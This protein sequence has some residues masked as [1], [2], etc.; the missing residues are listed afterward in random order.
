MTGER[1]SDLLPS[2]DEL[3]W[4]TP[5]QIPVRTLVF[6]GRSRQGLDHLDTMPGLPP[7][8]RGPYATMYVQR[9]WT[10]RQYAG[11]STA[12]GLQRLLPAQSRCGAKG[13][14]HRVRSGDAPRLRL[15][16]SPRVSGDVGMAG[17]AIDS[18][19]DMRTLFD[20]IPLD[21][22]ERVD[23]DERCRAT[24]HGALHRRG[25]RARESSR[26]SLPARSRT[27]S[28]KSSWFATRTSI[29]PQLRACASSPTISL[30]TP[31]SGCRSSTASASA[32]TT[33]R[34]QVRP[35]TW[36]LAYTLADGA[37]V[38]THRCRFGRSRRRRLLSAA[39]VFLGDWHE[40]LHGGC[41]AASRPDDLG[42][43]DQTRSHQRTTRAFRCGRTAKRAAGA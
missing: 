22:D 37:R 25:G 13:I 16:S 19:Q 9:P 27:T 39:V 5:E 10:V 28:L 21:Q 12:K 17:V 42:E 1:R 8:L 18:I 29:R 36:N 14:K 26:S 7:F 15:R 38:R 34:K 23:D 20:G 2:E 11:F 6:G 31:A 41:E 24:D 43:A 33:C 32:A 40:L 3:I 35:P 30:S 4:Q